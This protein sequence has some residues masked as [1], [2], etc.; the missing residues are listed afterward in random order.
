ME[1]LYRQKCQPCRKDS[2]PADAKEIARFMEALPDWKLKEAS[3][4]RRLVRTY[5]FKTFAEALAFANQV[6]EL[7]AS[8]NHHPRL[9]VDWGKTAVTWTTHAIGDVHANDFVM[10][11]KTD[12]V[13]AER[14]R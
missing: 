3:R 12:K 2:P 4:S 1:P 14:R 10:A 7:A 8:E 13:Y 5:R 9:L 6:G 11:A